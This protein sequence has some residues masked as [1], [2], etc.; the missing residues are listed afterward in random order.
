M[1]VTVDKLLDTWFLVHK[2]LPLPCGFFAPVLTPSLPCIDFSSP[3][4]V[5]LA[6]MLQYLCLETLLLIQNPCTKPGPISQLPFILSFSSDLC[7][8]TVPFFASRFLPNPIVSLVH[9]HCC[10]DTAFI[11]VVTSVLFAKSSCLSF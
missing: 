1:V 11:K 6:H 10:S 2:F 9:P 3:L 8:L 4:T 5:Q 7:V